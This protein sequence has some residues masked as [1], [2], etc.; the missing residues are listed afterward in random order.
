MNI[1]LGEKIKFFR[2]RAFLSQK[3]L[4]EKLG[5]SNKV[6]SKWEK[7]ICEP[8]L[9]LFH[10]M[11]KI[12]DF[13]IDDIFNENY[14]LGNNLV[15]VDV[16]D[17]DN[18]KTGEVATY[19]E[20]HTKGLWHK[21]VSVWIENKNGQ[22]LMQRRSDNKKIN[23]GKWAICAG[24]V[25]SGETDIDALTRIIE[26]ELNILVN[27]YNFRY[28]ITEKQKNDGV[29][30]RYYK[31]NISEQEHNDFKNKRFENV[32]ILRLDIPINK[33]IPNKE[34][35]SE[36]K[37][38]SIEEVG[39]LFKKGETCFKNNDFIVDFL[40]NL[41]IDL[42]D[43]VDENNNLTGKVEEKDEVHNKGLWH[44]EALVFVGNKKDGILCYKR[45]STT[46]INPGRIVPFF[47]GHILT[48]ESYEDGAI[49]ELVEETGLV[50]DKKSLVFLG[51]LKKS[52]KGKMNTY[53][54]TF[55]NYY[56]YKCNK[57]LKDYSFPKSEID[58]VMW[59]KLD[60]ADPL[61]FKAEDYVNSVDNK[62]LQEMR[63]KLKKY[64]EK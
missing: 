20:I 26:N 30:Y 56:F 53:N 19:D 34:E 59:K 52:A 43:V 1:N 41:K 22:F 3:T 24:H 9:V 21:E 14:D 6:V 37:W 60:E 57:K 2:N 25:Y 42:L 46:K 47:G 45:V 18:K 7:N 29:V 54:N 16:Y 39:E 10:K 58:G 44:R 51:Q 33:V 31:S 13:S 36:V 48:G 27:S 17:V 4:G 5:V 38:M 64:L 28:L 40:E 61:F 8:S 12:L 32:Y 11:S 23:P 15:Y 35:V 50:A 49:R 62:V 55:T 63:D